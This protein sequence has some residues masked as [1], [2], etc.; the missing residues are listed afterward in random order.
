MDNPRTKPT[1]WLWNVSISS[2]HPISIRF[3]LSGIH[4]C[5]HHAS[6]CTVMLFRCWHGVRGLLKGPKGPVTAVQSSLSSSTVLTHGTMHV[7]SISCQCLSMESLFKSP[8]IWKIGIYLLNRTHLEEEKFPFKFVC[9]SNKY[10]MSK[11]WKLAHKWQ[12]KWLLSWLAE[13]SLNINLK[14]IRARSK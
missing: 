9:T 4:L 11:R 1:E 6:V 14:S 2:K 5:G 13:V 7:L 8:S 10:S 3:R 12:L